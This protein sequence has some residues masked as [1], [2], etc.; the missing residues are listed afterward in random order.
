MPNCFLNDSVLL[1]GEDKIKKRDLEKIL[2]QT[3]S[4]ASAIKMAGILLDFYGSTEPVSY[5]TI[6]AKFKAQGGKF[7]SQG[8]ESNFKQTYFYT[9]TE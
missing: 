3:F 2:R 5:E 1:D 6:T 8:Y 9:K 7:L 4:N